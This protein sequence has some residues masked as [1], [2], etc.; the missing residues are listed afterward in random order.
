MSSIGLGSGLQSGV[1]FMFPH[2]FRVCLTAQTCK[3]I[4]FDSDSNMW[5]R[6]SPNMFKCPEPSNQNVDGVTFFD[7]WSKVRRDNL[8][9]ILELRL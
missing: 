5:F 6:E 1:L 9:M 7:M 2:I 3:S 8:I 4:D